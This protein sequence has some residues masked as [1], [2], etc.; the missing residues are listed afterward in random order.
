MEDRPLEQQ[1]LA[2][3]AEHEGE[4]DQER[5]QGVA[6]RQQHRLERVPA[7]DGGRRHRRKGRRRAH[8]GQHRVVEDEHVG[9]L[10]ADPERDQGRA[11]DHRR[12]DERRRHRH[13]QPEDEHGDGRVDR[14]Q[15]D[16]AA[17]GAD[18]QG[19]GL[20]PQP[21]QRHH[22]HDDPGGGAHRHHRQDPEG[23]GGQAVEHPP[24]VQRVSRR[25]KPRAKATTVAYSTARNGDSP[26]AMKTTIRMSEL[27]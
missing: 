26:T 8:L 10:F 24:G 15:G 17:G 1:P 2:V 16:R 11:D 5:R 21:G 7:G 9:G 12:D 4:R 27:N 22:G 23:A 25:R 20:E 13:G 3:G 14:G 6:Q 18:D 19:A